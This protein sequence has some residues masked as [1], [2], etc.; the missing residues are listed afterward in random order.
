MQHTQDRTP[1][2]RFRA[3]ERRSPKSG[4]I[5]DLGTW[6]R[7]NGCGRVLD[8]STGINLPNGATR[9]PDAAWALGERLKRLSMRSIFSG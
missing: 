9:S 5:V 2:R 7:K 8:L 1:R 4:L 3:T 6:A